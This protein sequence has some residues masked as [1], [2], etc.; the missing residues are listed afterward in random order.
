M[1]KKQAFTMAEVLITLGII[2]IIAAMTIPA[3]IGKW[4]KQVFINKVKYTYSILANALIMAQQEHGDPTEWDLGNEPSFENTKR[5]ADTYILPYLNTLESSR[6]FEKNLIVNLKNGTSL[7][8]MLDGCTASTCNPIW[9][10][11]LYIIMST[12]PKMDKLDGETRDYSREDC[13][14]LFRTD[15]K[16]LKFFAWTGS[17]REGIINNPTYG[18]NKNIPKN[19]RYNCGALIFYDGWQIKEDYPWQITH[20][21]KNSV[22]K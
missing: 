13:I 8:F 3:L 6:E 21:L 4:Q 9:L 15:I 11:N 20:K 14:F 7:M 17:T 5:V 19:K 10:N 16:N 1:F 22:N 18:C 2:G 12:K